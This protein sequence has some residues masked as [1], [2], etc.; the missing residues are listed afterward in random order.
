MTTAAQE[1]PEEETGG[2][3]IDSLGGGGREKQ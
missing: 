1:S 3:Q 2:D